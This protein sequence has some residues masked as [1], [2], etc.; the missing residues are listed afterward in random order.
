MNIHNNMYKSYETLIILIVYLTNIYTCHD[1]RMIEIYQ[2]LLVY[3]NH[4]RAVNILNH[5]RFYPVFEG[6]GENVELLLVVDKMYACNDSK[7]VL[8]N[9]CYSVTRIRMA[10]LVIN[11][12]CIYL[13]FSYLLKTSHVTH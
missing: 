7:W 4:G 13:I 6:W 1:G 8:I 10:A 9:Y 2:L 11:T 5:R 3:F 12:S